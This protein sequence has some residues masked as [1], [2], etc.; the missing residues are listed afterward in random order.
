VFLSKIVR[1]AMS[2]E[3]F[4]SSLDAARRHV[5]EAG[6]KLVRQREIVAERVAKGQHEAVAM[7]MRVLRTME[8]NLVAMRNHLRIEEQRRGSPAGSPPLLTLV[9]GKEAPPKAAP[10][11]TR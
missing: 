6:A 9:G 5:A 8:A 7:G 4:E 2:E 10:P 3:R 11:L 1:Q